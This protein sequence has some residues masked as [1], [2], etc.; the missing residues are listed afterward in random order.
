MCTASEMRVTPAGRFAARRIELSDPSGTVAPFA[1]WVDA[2]D[3]VLESFE[4]THTS[5]PWMRL[6][7]YS[8]G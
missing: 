6:V 3:V 5:E 1:A 2:H 4:D 7:E 8:R